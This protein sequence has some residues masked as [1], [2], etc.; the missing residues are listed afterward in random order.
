MIERLTLDSCSVHGYVATCCGVSQAQ[1]WR[2]SGYSSVC[3]VLK[4]A[5][6][7]YMPVLC[8][9]PA[10]DATLHTHNPAPAFC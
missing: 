8:A 9:M 5:C 2:A 10:C 3:V 1:C 4:L 6:A 7:A